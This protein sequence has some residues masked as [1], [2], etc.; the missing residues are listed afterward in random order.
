MP[1]TSPH[2]RISWGSGYVGVAAA[3]FLP[4]GSGAPATPGS[5]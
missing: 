2:T 1:I 3:V 5:R 4:P